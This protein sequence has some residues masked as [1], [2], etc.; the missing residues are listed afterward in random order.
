MQR[1]RRREPAHRDVERP[2]PSRQRRVVGGLETRAHHGQD[3]PDNTLRLAQG[4][5]EDEAEREG[6]LDRQIRES[7]LSTRPTGWRHSP[8]GPRVWREPQRHIPATDQGALVY[9]AIPDPIVRLVR[10]LYPRLHPR[11]MQRRPAPSSGSQ[12]ASRRTLRSRAPTPRC[13]SSTEIGCRAPLSRTAGTALDRL[14]VSHS[15][16]QYRLSARQRRH[17]CFS[18]PNGAIHV[19]YDTVGIRRLR[20]V[21]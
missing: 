16:P 2:S 20:R 15:G 9:P 21:W 8:R 4:Q 14:D 18:S 19:G 3:R 17:Q 11:I 1:S 10:R 5:A 6:G 13:S 7:R 12:P